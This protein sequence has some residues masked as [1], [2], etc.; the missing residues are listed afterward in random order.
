MN[1]RSLVFLIV[2]TTAT[3][4]SA[5]APAAASSVS[6]PPVYKP[7]TP[8]PWVFSNKFNK[9]KLDPSL[10]RLASPT[11]TTKW[12][13]SP[14]LATLIS[15]IPLGIS[16]DLRQWAEPVGNQGGV[17]SCA[18]WAIGYGLMGWWQNKTARIQP[19]EWFN[20]MSL[21]SVV[22]IPTD[23][24]AW[25]KDVFARATFPGVTKAANY[26][27]NEFNYTH[28]PTVAE[29]LFALPYRFS[30]WRTLFANADPYN[31]GGEA[32]SSMIKNEL[33]A[34]RPVPVAARVYSD[35]TVLSGVSK[36]SS[37]VYAKSSSA[38]YRGLHE[39][40]AVGYNSSGLLLQNSW[41][42]VFA[43]S[44]YIRVAWAYVNSD[45]FEAEVADG[46]AS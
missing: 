34:G 31:G 28:V 22:R 11:G 6:T 10:I 36:P 39:M 7:V 38:S 42:T 15:N 21:Y 12:Q 33:W 27:V 25:P 41:G 32:G 18:T 37:Y 44:G 8:S 4:S 3:S 46:I 16:S 13:V 5:A 24:G 17:G 43:S 40:L 9:A 30:S 1:K 20:P 26:S 35:F 14:R 23:R 2:A 45:I 29:N 19:N